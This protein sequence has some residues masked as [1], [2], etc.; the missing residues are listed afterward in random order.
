[1]AAAMTIG[2]AQAAI[3]ANFDGSTADFAANGVAT[4]AANLNLGTSGGTWSSVSTTGTAAN[5]F[6]SVAAGAGANSS[7]LPFTTNHLMFGID[8]IND[9]SQLSTATLDFAAQTLDGAT[10]SIDFGSLGGGGQTGGMYVDLY[11]GTTMVARIG[12]GSGSGGRGTVNGYTADGGTD[13]AD[14]SLLWA[15]DSIWG[16]DSQALVTLTLGASDFTVGN[17]V[18]GADVTGN[19]YVNAA[20]TFDSIVFTATDSKAGWGVDNISITAVPEPSSAALLGLGG[21]ALILR[22]RK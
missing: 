12:L 3:T 11:D 6:A 21:L 2:S 1:M 7:T 8:N 20:T 18:A 19:A 14:G 15:K 5:T 4:S 16:T 13:W 22:R 17:S 10:I 9:Q